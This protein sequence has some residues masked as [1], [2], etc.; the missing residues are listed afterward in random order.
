MNL[1]LLTSGSALD[2]N[3]VVIFSPSLVFIVNLKLLLLSNT[4]NILA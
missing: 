2:E 3:R 4:A 1:Y